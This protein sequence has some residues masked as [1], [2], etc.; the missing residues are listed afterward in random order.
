MTG[1]YRIVD[2]IATLEEYR[3]ICTGVGWAGV[4][5]FEAAATALPRSLFGVVAVLDDQVVGMGRIVGDGAIF[6]YLQDVAVLPEHQ[7]AGLGTQIVHRLVALVKA[8]APEKAFFGVFAAEGTLPFYQ[9]FD[10]DLHPALTGMFQ[11]VQ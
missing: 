5:N 2:R 9:K 6:Y 7:G 10:F 11:V 4:M 1:Q 3:H 8:N